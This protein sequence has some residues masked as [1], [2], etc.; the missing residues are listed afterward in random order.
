[1][2]DENRKK[3]LSPFMERFLISI[4]GTTLSIALTFGTTAL[5]NSHKKKTAQ[6]Q[7]AMLV[8]HDINNT[9]AILE[10]SRLQHEKY[11]ESAQ[12]FIEYM[13]HPEA[14]DSARLLEAV[15]AVLHMLT[16]MDRDN[17]INEST[18]KIF[19]GGLDV[20]SNLDNMR[21]IE[22]VQSFYYTRRT[23]LDYTNSSVN[24]KAPISQTEIAAQIANFDYTHS[25]TQWDIMGEF[26]RNKLKDKTI[27][28]YLDITP[29]RIR[30]YN[31]M[32]QTLSDLNEEN[33]FLMNISDEELESF[34]NKIEDNKFPLNERDVIGTWEDS[35]NVSNSVS[36][37]DEFRSDHS[38]EARDTIV[39]TTW[40]IR[41]K[42]KVN[43]AVGGKWEIKKDSLIRYYDKETLR[44]AIDTSG[45]SV[46][47]DKK[48]LLSQYIQSLTDYYGKNLQEDLDA[49][50]RM[51]HKGSFNLTRSKMELT[52]TIAA[53]NGE[54]YEQ[55]SHFKRK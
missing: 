33:M 48:E 4:L 46:G 51:A 31:S 32:I 34:V 2:S 14:A 3:G 35:Q 17:S 11:Y 18:E 10:N 30:E 40:Q 43:L 21:F 39:I 41:G 27:R 38:F 28:Y 23:W 24:W 44:T 6:R 5:V 26:L 42:I 22:N 47:E 50:P 54:P 25:F 29:N 55:T 7:T 1:M 37:E 36:H 12:Y 52:F 15:D 20:W 8:I 53:E 19:T 45:V 16:H 13:D 9:I 49:H